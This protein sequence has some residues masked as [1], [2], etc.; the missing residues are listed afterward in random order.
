MKLRTRKRVYFNAAHDR[1]FIIARRHGAVTR[2]LSR[3]HA[4]QASLSTEQFPCPSVEPA[5][6]PTPK[7]YSQSR[8]LGNKMSIISKPCLRSP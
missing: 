7:L 3:I 5:L 2:A 4:I 8:T 1:I 6:K